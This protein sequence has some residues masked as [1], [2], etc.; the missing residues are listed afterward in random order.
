MIFEEERMNTGVRKG[1]IVNT[2]KGFERI[3]NCGEF[4]GNVLVYR[5]NLKNGL[6]LYATGRTQ[7]K[8]LLD[9]GTVVWKEVDDINPKDK[10]VIKISDYKFGNQ[11]D[12]SMRRDIVPRSIYFSTK[13]TIEK[14]ITSLFSRTHILFSK[15]PNYLR[16]IQCFL[17]ALGNG[18]LCGET[19]LAQRQAG[20]ITEYNESLK[21]I[22]DF[23]YVDSVVP[24]GL[25][26]VYKCGKE[27]V[28]NNLLIKV[29]EQ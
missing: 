11:T 15:D 8:V 27:F 20:A 7:I 21:N 19:Y 5:L 17:I 4:V 1:T 10:V 23:S 29:G 14:Y 26:P 28:G 6:K 18:T 25:E 9:N 22:Y 2:D 16:T 13:K 3:E 12:F 24:E